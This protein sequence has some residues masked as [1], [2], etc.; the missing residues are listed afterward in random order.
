MKAE[1]RIVA[2]KRISKEMGLGGEINQEVR[3][4][5]SEELFMISGARASELFAEEREG[6]FE[7][8][9]A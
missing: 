7:E 8:D 3:E 1:Q 2:L 4:R 9:D 5:L 6:E